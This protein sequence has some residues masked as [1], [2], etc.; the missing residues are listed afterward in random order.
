MRL[1]TFFGFLGYRILIQWPFKSPGLASRSILPII[2]AFDLLLQ[3]FFL[4]GFTQTWRL[5]RLSILSRSGTRPLIW[6]VFLP[7]LSISFSRE[8]FDA[9]CFLF[10]LLYAFKYGFHNMPRSTSSLF[11]LSL[12]L[13]E[14]C[15]FSYTF[16]VSYFL[17]TFSSEPLFGCLENLGV[18]TYVG[19][20]YF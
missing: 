11:F 15:S 10:C 9:V 17:S 8:N 12:L 4:L 7:A 1:I 6:F 18:Y 13:V 5:T 3:L 14:R 19:K 20:Q 2:F 16:H